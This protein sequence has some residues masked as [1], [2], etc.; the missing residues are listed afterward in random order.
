MAPIDKIDLS[1]CSN[2]LVI[3]RSLAFIGAHTS[4][5]LKNMDSNSSEFPITAQL[6][7][8]YGAMTA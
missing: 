3:I 8:C 5:K 6:H 2:A 1:S 4:L 7:I